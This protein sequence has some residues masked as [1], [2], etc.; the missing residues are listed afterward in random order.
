MA[1]L[2]GEIK[3]LRS[4]TILAADSDYGRH[5]PDGSLARGNEAPSVVL[6][7]L[8]SQKRK[9]FTRLVDDYIL[10]SDGGI[11]AVIALDIDYTTEGSR[12]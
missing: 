10:G 7:V 6:E 4:T 1:T 11:R 3:D 8:Y 9:G 12:N 5:D 2:A